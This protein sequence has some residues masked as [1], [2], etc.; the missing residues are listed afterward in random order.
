VR[1]EGKRPFERSVPL[2]GLTLVGTRSPPKGVLINTYRSAGQR[3]PYRE[4]RLGS[5]TAKRL[6]WGQCQDVF[7]CAAFQALGVNSPTRLAGH[8]PSL[9]STSLR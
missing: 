5:F 9:G 6:G 8:S 4:T 7:V 1:G 3:Y 2:R